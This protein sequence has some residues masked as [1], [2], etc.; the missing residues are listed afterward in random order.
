[1]NLHVCHFS[2]NNVSINFN[3]IAFKWQV[4]LSASKEQLFEL[5]K[6]WVTFILFVIIERKQLL[7]DVNIS[8][9]L[10]S[11]LWKTHLVRVLIY[12]HCRYYNSFVWILVVQ[13]KF[14]CLQFHLLLLCEVFWRYGD[15]IVETCKGILSCCI[16]QSSASVALS[17]NTWLIAIIILIRIESSIYCIKSLLIFPEIV[18]LWLLSKTESIV[19]GIYE[20]ELDK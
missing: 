11:H 9:N 14:M 20:P 3:F 1:M 13:P 19:I 7:Q 16:M 18:R 4:G 2:A 5:L 17:F 10:L 12:I 6:H 15:T 8:I